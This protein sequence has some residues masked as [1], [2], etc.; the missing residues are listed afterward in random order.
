MDRRRP[1]I[2]WVTGASKGIGRDVA[3]ALVR[4]GWTVAASA[5]GAGALRDLANETSRIREYPLDITN[6]YDP[7]PGGAIL[8]TVISGFLSA[9]PG[10]GTMGVLPEMKASM[11][12]ARNDFVTNLAV[13]QQAVG[14]A[15][16]TEAA[17]AAACATAAAE[18]DVAQVV[19]N[20]AKEYLAFLDS[21]DAWVEGGLAP[22]L[23][24]LRASSAAAVTASPT[25]R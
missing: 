12:T 1:G 10:G 25:C 3:L 21:D 7:N 2:A 17:N 9:F 4:R 20:Q 6:V 23:S 22:R 19:V 11:E 18:R 14:V 13:L 8:N 24:A 16:A 15:Q 5:R